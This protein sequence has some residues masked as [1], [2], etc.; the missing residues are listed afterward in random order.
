MIFRK[1][2]IYILLLTA[3]FYSCEQKP[4]DIDPIPEEKDLT[5]KDVLKKPNLKVLDIGNS[6][7]DDATALLP[8]IVKNSGVDL[9]DFVLCKMVR[10]GASF[11]DWCNV[12]DDIDTKSYCFR[13]VIGSLSISLDSENCAAGDGSLFRKV[14][15]KVDWDVIII[16]Q[17]STYA[18]YYEMWN[19]FAPSGYLDK[20]ISIIRQYCPDAEIGFLLVHSYWDNYKGNKE[21]SSIDRWGKIALSVQQFQAEYGVRLIIPYGTAVENLRLSAANNEY[22]LTRDGSHCGKGLCQYVAACC[23]YESLL[24]PRNGVSC[25]GNAA[26]FDASQIQT[27]YPAISVTDENALLAQRAAVLAYVDMFHCNSPDNN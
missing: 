26:R 23:Y 11:M 17:V 6:Y 27:K 15:S 14:L 18:P 13:R 19:S 21:H 12:N 8:L 25:L 24:Y 7:T 10:G 9:S 1:V 3:I 4:L 20:F 16:H 2:F 5:L 22:D